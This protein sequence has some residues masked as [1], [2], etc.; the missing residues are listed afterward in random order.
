MLRVPVTPRLATRYSPSGL[1]LGEC[2]GFSLSSLTAAGSLPSAFITHRLL[3]P[4][5]SLMNAILL[6]S[7]LN[8][9]CMFHS[10]PDVTAV[11]SPP[12][13]GTV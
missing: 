5:R 1:Q 10:I 11:A 7:G 8:R 13:I 9:G 2:T 12:A 4:A 3:P 6:P